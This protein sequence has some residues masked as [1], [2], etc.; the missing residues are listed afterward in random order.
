MAAPARLLAFSG[1]ARTGSINQKLARAAAAAARAHGA[2]VTLAD[3]RDFPMPLYDGDL[4]AGEGMPEA[5]YRFRG[6]MAAHDGFLIASPEY[7]SSFTPLLKNTLDWASR[8]HPSDAG[9]PPA[10]RGKVAGLMS[11]SNGRL[12]GIRG[13]PHMRQVL[14]TLGVLVAAEQ[15]ALPGAGEAFAEDGSLK[16]ATFA[17][18]LDGLAASVVRLGV[19]L[20]G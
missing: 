5:A 10:F 12:G 9:P 4:E 18:M 19:A 13:L 15:L 2:E 11:A 14:T 3:L 17:K 1:S 16:D 7:N 6:L 8:K 20:K